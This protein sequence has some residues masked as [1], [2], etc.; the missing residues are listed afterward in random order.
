MRNKTF[1]KTVAWIT[2]IAMVNA[3]SVYRIKSVEKMDEIR[4]GLALTAD[5]S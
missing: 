5:N 4:K 1:L 2:L 3:C